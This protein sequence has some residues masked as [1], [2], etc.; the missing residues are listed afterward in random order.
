MYHY[1]IGERVLNLPK[2]ISNN[3]EKYDGKHFCFLLDEDIFEYGK[4]SVIRRK[5]VGKISEFEWN[6][7]NITGYTNVSPDELEQKIKN[8]KKEEIVLDADPDQFWLDT[9]TVDK[10]SRSNYDP[11][12]HNCQNFVQFCLKAVGSNASFET[13][14]T[15]KFH[16]ENRQGGG[17]C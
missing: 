16:S 10:W 11:F 9:C 15:N 12:L 14:W 8:E 13:D 2:I 5:N 17:P 1:E 6:V 3:A 4:N 7:R